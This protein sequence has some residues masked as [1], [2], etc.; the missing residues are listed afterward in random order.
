MGK[1]KKKMASNATKL[2]HNF[3]I[4]LPVILI[5]SMISII[6]FSYLFTYLAV[7]IN[8]ENQIPAN[9]LLINTSNYYNAKTK[10]I[11]LLII[12]A[13]FLLFLL[14][15]IIKTVVTNPGYFPEP[16]FL[17]CKIA[18]TNPEK[19]PTLNQI[20]KKNS[21]NG[22][23]NNQINNSNSDNQKSYEY[24]ENEMF[25]EEFPKKKN[26]FNSSSSEGHKDNINDSNSKLLQQKSNQSIF[27]N[28]S[29]IDNQKKQNLNSTDYENSK[30]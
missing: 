14:F 28:N 2:W 21:K 3:Q 17:E 9:F 16:T 1:L 11:T 30:L 25:N 10:G 7:L 18:A 20:A 13:F 5:L 27:I 19:N 15:S 23:N 24:L 22:Q 12:S 29:S 4:Y 26:T 6:Y 8:A